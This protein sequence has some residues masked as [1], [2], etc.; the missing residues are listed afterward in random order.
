MDWKTTLKNL[1]LEWMKETAP[2]F[3]QA[4]GGVTMKIKPYTDKTANGLT[5]C[6]IDWFKFHGGDANRIN[7]QGQ[8][9][10]V[11]CGMKWTHGGTRKGTADIHAIY[12][13]RHISIEIKIGKDRVSDSQLLEKS[14]V[15][16]AGGFYF[17][18]GDMPSFILWFHDLGKLI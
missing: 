7:T 9:R 15:E 17:I 12:K 1:K 10:K 5:N 3:F 4:S 2:G 13:G 11:N 14:R 8:L 6:I 18:A 16:K